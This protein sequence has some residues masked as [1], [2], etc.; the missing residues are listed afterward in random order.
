MVRK[1][2][3]IEYIRRPQSLSC[4]K[5]PQLQELTREFPW[6][7]SA[8]ILLCRNLKVCENMGFEEQLRLTAAYAGDRVRLHQLIMETAQ[9]AV[10]EEK[11]EQEKQDTTSSQ[12]LTEK[13]TKQE[14]KEEEVKAA[15][16]KTS[17]E[18]KL[19]KE[20]NIHPE[21]ELLNKQIL[22][23]AVSNSNLLEETE[24]KHDEIPEHIYLGKNSQTEEDE[25]E[26]STEQED[27]KAENFKAVEDFDESKEHSF[28]EWLHHFEDPKKKTE[29]EFSIAE[30]KK[31]LLLPS[32]TKTNFYSPIEMAKL[33]VKEDDDLITETLAKI[34]AQQ[35][36]IEKAIKAY[37]KLSLKYPEKKVYFASQIRELEKEL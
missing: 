9:V 26:F 12:T 7:Q 24:N 35:G 16:Q 37:N 6:F 25:E 13:E 20:E 23:H 19:S 3:F 2:E 33:S 8:Q 30:D 32:Q 22:S 28:S 15:R 21:E 17:L 29:K 5:T 4:D 14:K 31:S 18:E 36:N 34:Y 1:N 27:E 10:E 11:P